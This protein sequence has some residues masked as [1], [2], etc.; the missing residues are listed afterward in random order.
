M[1]MSALPLILG[2]SQPASH[3][4]TQAHAAAGG[5]WRSFAI[6]LAYLAAAACF[7]VG[8][9]KLGSPKSARRGN[10]IASLG[11]V[12]AVAA[13]L[14]NPRLLQAGALGWGTVLAG[15]AAGVIAG[16]IMAL[17]VD[18]RG[19]PQMVALFNGFGG[20]AAALVGTGEYIREAY[21]TGEGIAADV[22]VSVALSILIGAITF[23]GSLIA[24]AKLQEM[25]IKVFG[26]PI[27]GPVTLPAQAL[28][29][30]AS[31]GLILGL[32]VCL[33]VF[34]KAG[35]AAALL[36]VV[37]LAYG[38]VFVLPI[39]GADMPVVIALL[40]SFSGL[41]AAATGMVLHNNSLIIGG[42]LVGA[43]GLILTFIM[44]KAMNRSLMNVLIGG[45][46]KPSGA[47]A[48]GGAAGPKGSIRKMDPEEAAMVLD[49]AQSVIIIPGYGMA[50][51]Q[52]QHAVAELAGLMQ[53]RGATVKFAV[54]P[55]AGRMPGHM[56][57]LLAEANVS[58][59]LL[60]DLE[61]NPEFAQCD[62]ALV[63]GAN[64][65]VN[66]AARHDKASPIYGMPIF[67]ADKAKTVMI[68]KRSMNTGYA[69]VENELFYL[70]NAV[71]LFGDAKAV[72]AGINAELKAGSGH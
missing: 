40:N 31:A 8:L 29:N 23:T 13:T 72:V 33:A 43:S 70:P 66:P 44:C 4:V 58:Y 1:T 19:M 14:L 38:K 20:L 53:K 67:D 12:I 32:C 39:G 17:R 62:V 18:M 65:V 25:K 7:I 63:I 55:V 36:F 24:F 45:F 6:N 68:C 35:W 48:A 22:R 30:F 9:K 41:G 34:E 15:L 50:V 56:N 16:S 27:S 71:M 69:G 47:P 64:D 5:D 37:G 3:A 28:V 10:A 21:Y 59:E 49:A 61:I 57:V 11:M 60:A 2:Q 51:A 52:A 26:Q 46:G 42:S 54:H